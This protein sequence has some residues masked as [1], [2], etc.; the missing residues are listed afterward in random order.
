[1]ILEQRRGIIYAGTSEREP[2][3]HLDPKYFIGIDPDIDKNGFAVYNKQ[4][5]KLEECTSLK[6]FD[7][8]RKLQ[9]YDKRFFDFNDHYIVKIE[10]GWLSKNNNWHGGG[11]NQY[12]RQRIANN[13]AQN[14][15]AGKKI[16]EMCIEHDI[17]FQ[18][19]EPLT[20]IFNMEVYF[21]MITKWTGPTNKDSRSAAR[22]VYGF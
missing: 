4:R 2:T 8:L 12:L 14:H 9:E 21:R 15:Q 10:G 6:Y 7:L 22:Y 18:V 1:M 20:P 13:V 11:N 3:K 5:K 17:P 19:V 16:V